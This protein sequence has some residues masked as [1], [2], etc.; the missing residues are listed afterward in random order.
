M[1]KM[2]ATMIPED[3]VWIGCFTL[4]VDFSI[5]QLLQNLS[6]SLLDYP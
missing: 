3:D 2:E 6:F 5:Y 4:L 1:V